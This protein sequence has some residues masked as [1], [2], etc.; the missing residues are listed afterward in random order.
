MC[1]RRAVVAHRLSHLSVEPRPRTTWPRTTRSRTAMTTRTDLR[2][3]FADTRAD[4]LGFSLTTGALEPLARLDRTVGSVT[5]SL[6]LLGASHQV[7][8]DDGLRQICETVACLPGIQAGLP[9][10]DDDGYRFTASTQAHDAASLRGVVA[11]LATIVD[12]HAATGQP[13]L[14]G[15]F[16][17]EEDAVTA[18]I[19]TVDADRVGWRTW[20]TY[21]QSGEVVITETSMT[22]VALREGAPVGTSAATPPTAEVRR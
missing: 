3:P 18:I 6:R 1:S 21:P 14:L 12:A 4:H 11:D 22:P 19:A 7:I 10:V 15:H 2:V 5:V 13:A 9:D 20:H 8:V 16:P 17:G